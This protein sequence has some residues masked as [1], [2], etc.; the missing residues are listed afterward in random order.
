MDTGICNKCSALK[1]FPSSKNWRKIR[2]RLNTI[3][4]FPSENGKFRLSTYGIEEIG[5]VPRFPFVIRLTPREFTNKPTKKIKYRFICSAFVRF[6]I[7][8]PFLAFSLSVP[9]WNTFSF[10]VTLL[11][12][13][14]NAYM[15]IR[16]YFFLWHRKKLYDILLIA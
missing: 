6:I 8:V 3:V 5:E 1:F 4:K 2:S 16:I 15:F 13:H 9:Y 7:F 14:V 10:M 11:Y 12:K